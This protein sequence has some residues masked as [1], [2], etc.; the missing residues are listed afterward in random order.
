MSVPIV[1][2]ERRC[3][4]YTSAEIIHQRG[5]IMARKK[6]VKRWSLKDDLPV[7]GELKD[8]RQLSADHWQGVDADG[9]IIDVHGGPMPSGYIVQLEPTI[10]IIRPGA[11]LRLLD[12]SPWPGP[13]C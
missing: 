7:V 5:A 9:T 2:P 6:P 11:R 4:R 3:E 10:G 8:C 12:L 1:P 13:W